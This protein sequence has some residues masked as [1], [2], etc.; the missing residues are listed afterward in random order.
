MSSVRPHS[1]R[2]FHRPNSSISVPITVSRPN[3]MPTISHPR[4]GLHSIEYVE[5]PPPT[6][7]LP[8]RERPDLMP[9]LDPVQH[10]S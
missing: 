3:L 10:C 9:E 5:R 4:L 6:S 7:P 2:Q 8:I 1:H